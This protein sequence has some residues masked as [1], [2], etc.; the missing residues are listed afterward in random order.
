MIINS[1][2]LS[3]LRGDGAIPEQSDTNLQI[4]ALLLMQIPARMPQRALD[5][6]PGSATAGCNF[7]FCSYNDISQGPSVAASAVNMGYLAPGLWELAGSWASMSDF[8]PASPS[9][10]PTEGFAFIQAG[11]IL[12][13][14]W[15]IV[16][17]AQS[18]WGD[19][20]PPRIYQFDSITQ[21][22]YRVPAT[23]AAQNLRRIVTISAAR[24]V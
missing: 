15:N 14:P 21:L 5:A 23:A 19:T 3:S 24:L 11:A 7:S 8:N 18:P 20:V 12:A 13:I 10:M 9:A 2:I 1:T 16:F 4:P 17:H 22:V 6:A